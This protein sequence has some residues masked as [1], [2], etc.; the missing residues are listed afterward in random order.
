[1]SQLTGPA[2]PHSVDLT[3]DRIDAAVD[4]LL[5]SASMLS[6]EQVRE[7]S[8]LPGWSR[9]HVLTHVARNADGLRNL[10]VWAKT[11]VETPQYPSQ[12][13]RD[14]QIEDGSGRP[15][16][17]IAADISNSAKEFVEQARELSDDEWLAE[18]RGLRGPAHPAWFTLHRRIFEVEIHHVDLAAGY[19]PAA[20]PDWF[21][22]EHLYRITGDLATGPSAAAAVLTDSET[23]RQYFLRQDSSAELSITGT[24]YDLLA[25]LLGR[26]DGSDLSPDPAGPLPEIPPY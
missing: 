26:S 13:V 2:G 18:V 19:Q 12:A 6:D 20:W 8:A 22:A 23:G 3:I 7:P 10:L 21:V 24:G 1:V 15:A 5:A 16:G 17:E 9:G 4:R 25:W 11:G 14:A